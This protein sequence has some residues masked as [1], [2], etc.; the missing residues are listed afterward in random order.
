LP[1]NLNVHFSAQVCAHCDT[2]K[3][4]GCPHDA[5]VVIRN[6]ELLMGTIDEAAI[7]AFKGKIQDR[8]IKEIGSEAGAR[9]I[10]DMTKLA[11]RAIMRTG[12]SFGIADEDIPKEARIQINEVLAKAEEA[13]QNLIRSYQN[14]EL[15]PLPG[16]TLD[17]TIE[18]SIMQKLGKARDETGGIAD[19]HMGLENSAVIMARSGARGSIL[20]LTQMAAC[21]GQQA[22]RGER[23]RRGYAGRTLPHFEEGDLG[24]D[25]HGFVK[26][27]YKSGLSP[28]EYFFH[29]IG[30]RE[31]LVDTA[32]RTSQSGYL[33][34]RL[35][36]A[37]QDLEV[38]YDL[39]VRDTRGV[40]VQFKYGED[41]INSTKSDFSK[42]DTIHKIIHSVLNRKVA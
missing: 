22:V 10:D 11:I 31:G 27:S 14:K 24:S 21:V 39:T 2:C 20:N 33:Q 30:G 8:I 42:P 25:A 1:E 3:K 7:G 16:R 26:A 5:Y 17:E 28:T 19:S 38:Q 4:E 36:N 34:R 6:G 23:I 12:L 41:G 9:F 29:A 37:L 15:E 32:V 18:M 35:V 40:L 13:V